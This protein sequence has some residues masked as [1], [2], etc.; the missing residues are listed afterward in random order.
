MNTDVHPAH[1]FSKEGVNPVLNIFK[2]PPTDISINDCRISTFSP[3]GKSI[4]PIQFDLPSMQEFVDLSRSYFTMRLKLAM[5]D[6]APIKTTDDLFLVNNLAHSMIKQLTVRLNGTLINPHTDTYPYKAMFETILNYDRE[7][8]ETLLRPQGWVNALDIPEKWEKKATG[9]MDI[10]TSGWSKHQQANFKLIQTESGRYFND[11]DSSLL[12]VHLKMRPHVEPFWFPYALKPGVQMQFEI[13]FH[14]PKFWSMV[15][16]DNTKKLRF[17]ESDID[18]RFH[19]ARLSL[20]SSI[21]NNLTLQTQNNAR[22]VT[23]P[24]VRSELRT[25]IWNS[26]NQVRFEENNIFNGKVPQRVLLAIVDSKSFNGTKNYYPFSFLKAKIKYIRQKVQGEE[27]P[28]ETLELTQDDRYDYDGY[29]RFLQA[30]GALIKSQPNMMRE[31]DWGEDRYC[32]L[33]MWNNVG[34]GNADTGMMNPNKKGDVRIEI[35]T[36]AAIGVVTTV[37]IYGEFENLV[38]VDSMNDVEYNIYD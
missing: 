22:K 16:D 4:T 29:Y 8:G 6:G 9:N 27:Y 35:E 31:E 21:Y 3:V 37:L 19:L 11:T 30:S 20:N 38:T 32:N 15:A 2:V 25:F 7:D 18:M 13:H 17:T 1:S 5:S 33:F 28:Y 36:H 24:V 26:D 14:D 23:Y 34:S 10:K 12:E